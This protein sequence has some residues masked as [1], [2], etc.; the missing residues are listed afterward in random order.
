V[1]VAA[2]ALAADLCEKLQGERDCI[3]VAPVA[4]ATERVIL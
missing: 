3:E 2:V 1:P 4:V